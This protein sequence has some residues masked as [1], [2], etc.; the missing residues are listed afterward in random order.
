M[1]QAQPQPVL[2][3]ESSKQFFK[4]LTSNFNSELEDCQYVPYPTV[5]D[6]IN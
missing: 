6:F 3:P 1:S 2:K 4:I 5:R